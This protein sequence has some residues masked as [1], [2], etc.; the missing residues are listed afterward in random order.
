METEITKFA[1]QYRL[2][3]QR[4]ILG[5]IFVPCRR[6]QIY[7]H[8]GSI[9]GVLDINEGNARSSP[10]IW[11]NVRRGLL[12]AGFTLHQDGDSEGSLLFDAHNPEMGQAAIR[13]MKAKRKRLVT[14]KLIEHLGQIGKSRRFEPRGDK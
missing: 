7:L 5:E 14:I 4:D 9:L 2:R 10:N 6:G 12:G 8:G 1:E 13:W 11:A 3:L